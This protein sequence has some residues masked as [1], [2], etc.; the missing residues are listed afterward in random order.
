MASI[1]MTSV[2]PPDQGPGPNPLFF[3]VLAAVV[4]GMA[5]GAVAGDGELLHSNLL[6]RFVVGGAVAAILYITAA[7]MWLAWHRRTFTK[8]RIAS[9]GVD[10]PDVREEVRKRDLEVAEFMG[11]TTQ[12]LED[13]GR[14]LE[15]LEGAEDPS[16]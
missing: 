11:A 3:G 10:A 6:F 4:I 15:Q 8:L 13:V 1:R 9:S 16:E 14:R 12:A 5:F 7:A 2:D